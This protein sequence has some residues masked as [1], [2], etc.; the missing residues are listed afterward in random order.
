MHDVQ[1][2]NAKFKMQNCSL[3]LTREV[4]AKGRRRERL[5]KTNDT[6]LRDTIFYFVKRYFADAKTI[7]HRVKRHSPRARCTMCKCKIQNAKFKI[8]KEKSKGSN[9]SLFNFIYFPFSEPVPLPTAFSCACAHRR[10][11]GGKE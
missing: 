8:K 5:F 7:F 3:H 10:C 2:Q 11:T 4:D 1:M 9:G 6:S